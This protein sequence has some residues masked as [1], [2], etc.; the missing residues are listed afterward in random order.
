MASRGVILLVDD[1]ESVRMLLSTLLERDS[2]T[3]LAA[4]D[5]EHALQVSR[6]HEGDIDA[7]VTDYK[8]PRLNGLELAK[9]LNRERPGMRIMI[10]SGRMSNPEGIQECGFP[11]V[12]KPFTITTFMTS[13]KHCLESKQDRPKRS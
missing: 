1:E 8:M 9:T 4:T 10:M 13:L 6:G 5:G 12:S 11:M 3:V 7:L 2:Y